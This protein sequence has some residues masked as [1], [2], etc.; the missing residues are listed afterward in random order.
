[1]LFMVFG[2][3]FHSDIYFFFFVVVCAKI[4]IEVGTP[5]FVYTV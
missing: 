4:E 1:M 3:E 5:L 2:W